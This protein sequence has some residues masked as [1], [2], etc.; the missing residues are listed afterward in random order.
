MDP[1]M[2]I[3]P[4]AFRDGSPA[5][6]EPDMWKTEEGSSARLLQLCAGYFLFYV[7]TGLIVKAFTA[8][9]APGAPARMGD[10]AF[11]AY[12]TFGANLTCLIPVLLLGW[13]RMPSARPW[14]IGGWRRRTLLCIR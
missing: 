8:P 7:A 10:L 1:V 9:A 6:E 12:N 2:L 13:W 4:R 11:L 3:N 14:R 5:A